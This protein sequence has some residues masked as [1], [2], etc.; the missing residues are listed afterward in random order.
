MKKLLTYS[1]LLLVIGLLATGTASGQTYE[2]KRKEILNQQAKTRAEINVLDARIRSYQKRVAEAE[3][4]F[5]KSYRQFENLNSLIALQDDKIKSLEEEQKQIEA[6]IALTEQE[7]AEREKE[8]KFLIDNYK[9]ILLFAYKNGSSNNLELLL[10]ANSFNQALVRSYYLKKFEEQKAKQAQQIRK[11]KNEL[12]QVRINLR[13]SLNRNQIV[14]A[15]IKKEKEKLGEQRS[16]QQQT[17]ESIRN[18][19][20][21]LLEQ[22]QKN[23]RQK[24]ALENTFA[25]LIKAEEDIRKAENERLAKLAAARRIADANLRNS[26]VAKYSKPIVRENMVSEEM[27]LSYDEAFSSSKGKL[28]WPV[29]SRTVSKKFGRTR[30]PVYGTYTEHLGINIVAEP[31]SPV[32]VVSDGY[33][34]SVTIVPGYG[35]VVMV[36]HGTYYTL[37]GNLSQIDVAKYQVLKAG[38]RI[39]LS[40]VADSPLGENLFFMIRKGQ[41]NLNPQDWLIK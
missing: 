37:Y 28:N 21:N 5:N 16:K 34:F 14:I 12:D 19:R 15:E 9:K 22:L 25:T 8:L 40:G 11:R 32:R 10:T 3:E 6:E 39:G 26:E 38:D 18:E 23:R 7:I 4:E 24:E 29:N 36:N 1:S 13:Q 35:D 2:E 41:T 27:L 20:S 33:V 17:V 31:R 30:N